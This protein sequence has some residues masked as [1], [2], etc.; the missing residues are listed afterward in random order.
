MQPGESFAALPGVWITYVQNAGI[1]WGLFQGVNGAMIWL[2]V[3]AF[4]LL[5]FYYDRFTTVLQKIAYALIMVG[6]WGNLIDRGAYGYVID[7]VDVHWWPVFNVADS[8]ITVAIVLLVI[9]ELRRG[10]ETTP[11]RTAPARSR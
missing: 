5:V 1:T 7:F 11:S 6:L 8:C 9:A 2:S 4:G 3:A 10:K